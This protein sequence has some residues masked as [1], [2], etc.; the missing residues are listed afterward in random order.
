MRRDAEKFADMLAFAQSLPAVRA[1]VKQR[2]GAGAVSRE[3]VLAL[4]LRLLAVGFFRVGWDRYA[5]DHGHVGL[6]TLPATRYS[7]SSS[8]SASTTWRRPASDA[9]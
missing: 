8:R 7:C 5:R 9:A 2:L 3:R 4:A 6:T 1:T